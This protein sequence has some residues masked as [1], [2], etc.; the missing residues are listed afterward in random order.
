MEK[1]RFQVQLEDGSEHEVSFGM[2]YYSAMNR[3]LLNL[4]IKPSEFTSSEYQGLLIYRFLQKRGVI[5]AAEFSVDAAIEYMEESDWSGI[6][7]EEQT[8]D[9]EGEAA[10]TPAS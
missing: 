3:R 5:P 2:G 4:G 6:P 1:D 7:T 9:D 8:R 10:A